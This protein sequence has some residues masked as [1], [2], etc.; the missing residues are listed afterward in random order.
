MSA[1]KTIGAAAVTA[2]V[3]AYGAIAISHPGG[4]DLVPPC[5]FRSLT[6][7]DCP[8]CGATR[9][10]LALVL[11]Q[12]VAAALDLNALYVLALPVV[13]FAIAARWWNGRPPTWLTRRW[14]PLAIA[15]VAVAFTV[16]RNLPVAP[17]RYLGT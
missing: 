10:T 12:D 9:A 14:T 6:G 2:G 3:V 11:R 16:V 1:P 5:P 15:A 4:I 17:F 8:L 7:L 13:A